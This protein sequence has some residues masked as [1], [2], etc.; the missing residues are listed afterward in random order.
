MFGDEVEDFLIPKPLACVPMDLERWRIKDDHMTPIFESPN[1]FGEK[2]GIGEDCDLARGF[3]RLRYVL[4]L[5]GDRMG[6]PA[7][8]LFPIGLAKRL[9]QPDT[10][11]IPSQSVDIVKH[12]RFISM[13][14]AFDVNPEWTGVSDNPTGLVAAPFAQNSTL[15]NAR[16]PQED[17]KS[18]V[19]LGKRFAEIPQLLICRESR[20]KN[21]S[22]FGPHHGSPHSKVALGQ[23]SCQ[24]FLTAAGALRQK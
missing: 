14:V 8:D 4:L 19:P 3:K 17:Q 10:L 23:P 12:N 5:Q 11:T 13:A 7:N 22:T 2:P 6:V 21:G 16:G 20:M 1:V 18:Q 15:P 9:E 24:R